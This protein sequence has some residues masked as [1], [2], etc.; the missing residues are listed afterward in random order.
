MDSKSHWSHLYRTKSSDKVSWYQPHLQISL[1][2]IQ[3]ACTSKDD[4]IIDVGGGASTLVDDLIQSGFQ[5]ITVLDIAGE[6]LMLAQNRIGTKAQSVNWIEKDVLNASLPAQY[7]DL[8]HD[9]A[10]FHFLTQPEDRR[11]YV[12][13]VLKAMR[14]GGHVI[15]AAF[16][17]DGP[18]RCSGLDVVRYSA[19]SMLQELG[20]RF[21]LVGRKFEEHRTPTSVRQNFLYCHF[22]IR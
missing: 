15:I 1:E 4:R 19:E 9:R 21:E 17:L 18:R 11:K 10:V 14:N 7:Y 3:S 22:K 5:N 6:A 20:D 16:S 2:M 8:W 13:T 12:E